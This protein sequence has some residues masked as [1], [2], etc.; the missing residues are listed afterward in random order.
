MSCC[1]SHDGHHDSCHSRCHHLLTAG[2][3]ITTDG[4]ETQ[5]AHSADGN[6]EHPG[7]TSFCQMIQVGSGA[8]AADT[9]G[10]VA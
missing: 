8:G 2:F 5:V 1:A 7:I 10:G 3:L 9:A 6:C 4:Y